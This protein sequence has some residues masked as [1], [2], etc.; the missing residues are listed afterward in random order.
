[1]SRR[2]LS[3]AGALCAM[4]AL[5]A[6][7]TTKSSNPLS[8]TVAGP[9]PGVNITAPKVLEPSSGTK[10]AVDKQPVTLLVENS[11]T[12]GVRP[13]TYVFDVATDAN[14]TNKVFSRAGIA[15]GDGGRTSLRLPDP[16]ATARTYFWR[17]HAEDGANTGPD[18]AATNF[19]VFTPIVI[20]VPGLVSPAANSTVANLRPSFVVNNAPR[21]GPV[22]NI[23][24]LIEVADSEAFTNKVATGTSGEQPNQTTLN[25]PADLVYSKIY[26][27]H[28][29]AY[30]PTTLGPWSATFAFVTPAAPVI[31][32]PPP[33]PGP[34]PVG[35]A[36]NDA[37]N[38]GT[39]AVYNSPPDIASWPATATITRLDMSG[40][41]GLSFQFTAQN[42]WP[43]VVPPGWNGPLQYTVWAVVNING[44]WNTS[45]FIQMWRGR[46]STGA[47]IL[48]E[49]AR[50]WAYDS[51]WGP[52]AGYQPHAGEQMGF[53][54]SAGNAR[55]ETGVSSVRERTNV[56]VVALPPG[57]NGSFSF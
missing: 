55:G 18:S 6:C 43:D 8:P 53:F 1:M 57:D 11:S 5:I 31:A 22:G 30:D 13:L 54:L 15:P 10:I 32:P 47:P 56:V 14:F 29:R 7:E 39:A 49:F 42:R 27:W 3:A 33:S 2:L 40:S 36:A 52:M 38:L 25:I 45:G 9:I 24:Y 26:Y 21:S 17:A 44:R 46:P 35:P 50:N 51:R 19:D 28:V 4:V 12:S 34:G 23:T 20:N 41:A 37:I 16:L 48:A